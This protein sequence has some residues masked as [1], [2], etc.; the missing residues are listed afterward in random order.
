M[1]AFCLLVPFLCVGYGERL[2]PLEDRPLGSKIHFSAIHYAEGKEQPR[3]L[4]IRGTLEGPGQ[5]ELNPNNLKLGPNGKIQGS[6]TEGWTPIPVRIKLVDT[7]DPDKKGRKFYDIVPDAGERQR[8]FSLIL[9]PN[10]A[11]PHHLLIWT[12]EKVVGTYPIVDPDRE[13]HQELASK[14]VKASPEEQKAIAEL[15]KVFGYSFRFRLEAND[16]VTYLYFPNGVEDISKLD[17]ALQGLKNLWSLSFNGGRLGPDGLKSIGRM[18]SLKSLDF[19]RC[20]ID[21]AGLTCLKDA[22]QLKSMSFFSSRGLSDNGVAR[23]QELKSLRL[24]DLR[25]ESFSATE[26]KAPRITDAGLKHLA[27]LTKLGYLNLQGQHITD[28]GLNHLSKM[29]NLETLSLSF[30]GITDEGLKRLEGLQK[31]R[32]LH[33]Y[34]TRVTPKGIATLKAKLPML[35]GN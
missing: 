12:G 11:G 33:L 27:G 23:L 18:P 31:L 15:R 21:D 8:K 29:T 4:I 13:E 5:L 22:T 30:A 17:A 26:P 10:E 3:E 32:G 34:G 28:D 35:V 24:L 2:V 7:P 6:T 1:R 19:T 25:N 9:A 20:E 14:L 16:A